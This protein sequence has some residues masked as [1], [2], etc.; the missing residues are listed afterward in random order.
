MKFYKKFELLYFIY[1]YLRSW[2]KVPLVLLRDRIVS[3]EAKA[4]FHVDPT[5][6]KAEHVYQS[7]AAGMGASGPGDWG[8]GDQGV[9]HIYNML[10]IRNFHI[11]TYH[12]HWSKRPEETKKRK[13]CFLKLPWPMAGS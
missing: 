7:Y 3:K 11:K 13:E 1:P 9:K 4:R 6:N 2:T 5:W 8:P 12:A 10:T